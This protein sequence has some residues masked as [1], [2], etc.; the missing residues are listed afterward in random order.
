MQIEL[1]AEQEKVVKHFMASGGYESEAEIIAEALEFFEQYDPELMI[2]REV[3]KAEI[4]KGIEQLDRGEGIP[5]DMEDFIER[6]EKRL[7]A[8]R[9]KTKHG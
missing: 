5:W 6:G 7:E 8:R 9:R 4:Q 3:L 2:K 1:T